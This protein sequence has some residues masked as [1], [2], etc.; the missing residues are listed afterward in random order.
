[1]TDK[2]PILGRPRSLLYP[3]SPPVTIEGPT[4]FNLYLDADPYLPMESRE[5]IPFWSLQEAELLALLESSRQGLSEQTATARYVAA[6]K[7]RPR[8]RIRNLRNILWSQVNNPIIWLLLVSALLSFFLDDAINAVIIIVIIFSS[9]LLG[10]IQE[11]SAA[12]AVA[13]LLQAIATKATVLRHNREVILPRDHLVPGDVVRL[14]AGSVVPGDGRLLEAKELW[15][16]ESSLTGESFPIEKTVAQL[17][18][19]TPL[20][21]RTNTVFLGTHIVS[22]TGLVI[23]AN[24]GR[25]TEL[26]RISASLERQPPAS[27]FEQGL[28]RF[29]QLLLGITS[30]LGLGVFVANLA[31]HRT[32]IDSML[33]GLA[34]AVGMTPQ[35]LPAIT[36]VVLARGAKSLA[37]SEVI[38]KRLLAIEN[39]GGMEIL[40]ADKTGTITEGT[41]QLMSTEDISGGSSP[42]V[43][44]YASI[45]AFNQVGF[46]NPIDDAIRYFAASRPENATRLDEIPY[47]F[48][49]KRLTVLIRDHQE[50]LMVTKG[51]LTNVLE[52]CTT[53]ERP[54][55]IVVPLAELRDQILERFCYL[56]YQGYRVLGL[57][58]RSTSLAQVQATDE[59]N[60]CFIGFLVF[61][62]PIKPS[63]VRTIHDL[64]TLG[65]SLKVITGDNR[66]VAR[67]VGHQVG[68]AE[69]RL[70]TGEQIG[71]LN[72][73][74]LRL[75]AAEADIFAEVEPE[76]K[77]RIVRA[78]KETGKIVGFLGDGINDAPALH[79]ADIGISVSK[80]VDVAR[81]AAQVVLLRH[82]LQVLA[83]GVREGRRTLANTL[84]Y[85]FVSISANFG[86]M[87]SLAIASLYLPFL[88]LLPTQILLINLLADFP[89]M[90]MA[91]DSVDTELIQRPRKW[92]MQAIT[93][94]MLLFGLLGTSADL[95]TFYLLFELLKVTEAEFRTTWFL[96]SVMTGLLIM[97]TAR[98]QRPFFRSR[99]GNLLLIAT[100]GVAAVTWALP[101]TPLGAWF[102]LVP[103]DAKQWGLVCLISSLYAIAMESGKQFFYRQTNVGRS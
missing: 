83:Q 11:W 102:H 20:A 44:R 50:T 33:F 18:A 14:K 41:V 60:F 91:T 62:D 30:L 97:L 24:V 73:L 19:A 101:W 86:Y 103:P 42:R 58:T 37:R 34:L 7:S 63:I 1:V 74:E 47:D 29:G 40:C 96:V 10:F 16:N 64:K 26:G 61:V 94:F 98:T 15:V 59:A 54:D 23:L 95:L 9:C 3:G 67:S 66:I 90:A 93:W 78:L 55:G 48:T 13:K 27:A 72:S 56:G 45:N 8:P 38:V 77:E 88:P 69:P 99:P 80:A 92:D 36:S 25:Q 4:G 82:D 87:L 39:F 52:I 57:A 46:E 71:Q 17:P 85:V 28:R 70:I 5:S 2:A 6:R 49:R 12:D 21:A 79:A 76:Q 51:A 84:K 75:A 81:E 22:G 100:G 32:V 31:F 65:I 53:A 35:L 43:L 68:F 89:A